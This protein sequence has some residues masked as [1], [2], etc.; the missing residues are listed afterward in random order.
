MQPHQARAIG[1]FNTQG[2]SPP[3]LLGLHFAFKLQWSHIDSPLPE[4]FFM[5]SMFWGQKIEQVHSTQQISIAHFTLLLI[6]RLV[7]QRIY[8]RFKDS[9][10]S[11]DIQK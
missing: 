6:H 9:S 1:A 7:P 5:T 10:K 3:R 2:P 4:V 8:A 11:I